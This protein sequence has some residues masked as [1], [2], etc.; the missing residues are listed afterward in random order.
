MIIR[1]VEQWD[2]LIDQ[3]DQPRRVQQPG[4]I[5]DAGLP[6]PYQIGVCIFY[7][8][9]IR[10]NI[11]VINFNSNFPKK[12]KNT[13][14]INAFTFPMTK[15]LNRSNGASNGASNRIS[16]SAQEN[17][18]SNSEVHK[19]VFNINNIMTNENYN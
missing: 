18:H 16:E 3:C 4:D 8:L 2:R 19:Y 5:R 13:F 12:K 14:S 9:R 15:Y 17:E 1:Q 6:H 7:A 11:M 10:N